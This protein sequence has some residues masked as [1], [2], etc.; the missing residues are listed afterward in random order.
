MS[1]SRSASRSG[2]ARSSGASYALGRTSGIAAAGAWAARQE[3]AT[4][5]EARCDPASLIK[6]IKDGEEGPHVLSFVGSRTGADDLTIRSLSNIGSQSKGGS[7]LKEPAPAAEDIPTDLFSDEE[8]LGREV[9]K[10]KAILESLAPRFGESLPAWARGP[11]SGSAS[12]SRSQRPTGQRAMLPKQLPEGHGFKKRADPPPVIPP[13]PWERPPQEVRPGLEA[14]QFKTPATPPPEKMSREEEDPPKKSRSRHRRR[15]RKEEAKTMAGREAEQLKNF[16]SGCEGVYNWMRRLGYEMELTAILEEHGPLDRE[17]FKTLTRPNRAAT[18]LNYVR[19]MTRLLEWRFRKPELDSRGGDLDGRMGVLEYVEDL[20]SKQ[21]GFMT[22]RS[23]LYAIDF[24]GVLFG[25]DAKG[26]YWARAKKLAAGYAQSKTTPTSRAPAFGRDTMRALEMATIDPFLKKPVRAACGKLR[27]SIQSS[28]RF[29]DLL[30]TP[31]SCC[32]WIR[33]PGEPGIIGL[34]SRAVRGKCGPRLWVASFKAVDPDNDRWLVEL[35]G[36]LLEAH[37]SAWEMDDHMGKAA[38]ASGDHFISS[39][40]KLEDDVN[41]V[42]EGLSKLLKDSIPVGMT[43][44]QIDG[45]RWHGAKASMTSIMQHLQLKKRE[46][47][48]QGSW[49]EKGE[50]MPDTYLREGQTI[51]LRA[52][53]KCLAYLRDGGDIYT[54]EGEQVRPGENPE[55]NSDDRV[56]VEKAMAYEGSSSADVGSL[57]KE[58]LDAGFKNG[59]KVDEDVLRKER[60]EI[61]EAEVDTPFTELAEPEEVEKM[62]DDVA[63]IDLELPADLGEEG[64]WDELDSEGLTAFWVVS[65]AAHGPPKLHLPAPLSYVEGVLQEAKPKCG[66]NG[67]YDYIKSEEAWDDASTLCKRCSTSSEG[68]CPGICTHMHLGKDVVVRRCSRRCVCELGH[69]ASGKGDHRCAFHCD[70]ESPKREGP[71]GED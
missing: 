25:F 29:D 59:S 28:T 40:S 48:F 22:P 41:L 66:L 57:P 35:M 19:L 6:M 51:V 23:L 33:R 2:R 27:L 42:K 18:G 12:D 10:Q 70:P 37:G 45:L 52:Q 47:R 64:A 14:V 65:K 21:V 71:K 36:L 68:A 32:E 53:E 1:H 67:S 44:S 11:E 9:E 58:F 63:S 38:D 30:N 62:D 15:R 61:Q 50:N 54:L 17:R 8:E 31:I 34:R 60:E 69:K 4:L 39:P 13:R 49:K 43:Q 5:L 24:F 56:R 3:V 16:E 46:V 55:L 7:D 20:I 26:K